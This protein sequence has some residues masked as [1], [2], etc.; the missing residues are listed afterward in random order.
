[1]E[2]GKKS[3]DSEKINKNDVSDTGAESIR[4]ANQSIKTV[5]KT[6]KT[7]AKT[8]KTAGK[9]AKN[10]AK[11][12][13]RTVKITI[14]V[15]VALVK[16]IV[17]VWE[18]AIAAMLNPI[19]WIIALLAMMVI[20]LCMQIMIIIN[21]STTNTYA[22][23]VSASGL[24]IV[25]EEFVHG[26]ELFRVAVDKNRN[27]FYAMI[28]S[29]NDTGSKAQRDLMYM[30]KLYPDE[31]G[32]KRKSIFET[33]LAS[34]EYKEVL[35]KAWN[36]SVKEPQALAVA[37]VYLQKQVNEEKHTEMDIYDVTYTEEVMDTIVDLCIKYSDNIVHNCRCPHEDCVGLTLDLSLTTCNNTHTLHNFGLALFSKDEVMDALG[38]T[39]KEKEW[40]ALTEEYFKKYDPP[41]EGS[42]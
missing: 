41:T 42:E 11:A 28:Q 15:T 12:I 22:A 30:E 31:S 14:K 26:Q 10:S 8:V 24:G 38:F 39:N 27:G 4:L 6:V 35:E 25:D 40:E 3:F 20:L 21:G 32:A 19:V 33:G 9:T 16:L 17:T 5:G 18:H 23:Y 29:A 34:Y 2:S 7:T 37:Y 13:Y 36:I 1:M